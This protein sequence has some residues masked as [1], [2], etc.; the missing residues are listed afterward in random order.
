MLEGARQGTEQAGPTNQWATNQC[1]TSDKA[2]DGVE[3]SE[4][5]SEQLVNC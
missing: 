4:M 3:R 2:N 1:R 5:V